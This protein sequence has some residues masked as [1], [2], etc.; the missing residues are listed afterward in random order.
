MGQMVSVGFRSIYCRYH[1]RHFETEAAPDLFTRV[2][3]NH[4][5]YSLVIYYKGLL[6]LSHQKSDPAG[7]LYFHC[8]L[9]ADQANIILFNLS[10]RHLTE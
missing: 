3:F 4:L 8:D 10:W 7:W 5:R 9:A 1:Y 6:W 2:H